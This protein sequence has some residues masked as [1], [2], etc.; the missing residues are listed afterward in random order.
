VSKNSRGAFGRAVLRDVATRAPRGARRDSAPCRADGQGEST[1]GVHADTRGAEERGPSRGTIDDCRHSQSRGHPTSGERPTAWRTFLRAHW[2]ALVA[3]DFFTT[4]VWTARGLVGRCPDH[5]D[6]VPGTELQRIRGALRSLD[7]GGVPR[8]RDPV[9][10]AT[11]STHHRRIRGPLPSRME[12]SR[13][14][15][16]VDSIAPASGWPRTCSPPPTD[17]WHVGLLLPCRV[18]HATRSSCRTLRALR[19]E[20]STNLRVVAVSVVSTFAWPVS[21]AIILPGTL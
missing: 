4:E 3:A 15:G 5:P 10:G 17:R 11:P 19:S 8:S 16:R 1:L 7:Q 13:H 12:S 9:R 20:P 2:P 21:C 18:V 14:R 6:A